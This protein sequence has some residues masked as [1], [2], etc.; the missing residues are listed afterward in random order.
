MVRLAALGDSITLGMG[1]P[2]P[3]GGWRG[4]AALLADSAGSTTFRNFASSGALSGDVAG[5]Q[6]TQALRWQPDLATVLVGMNDCL[7]GTFHINAIGSRLHQVVDTLCG[8]RTR[9]VLSCL[10]EPGRMLGLPA[11]LARPL[12]RRVQAINE[13][14]HA[15]AARYPVTHLHLADD[16]ANVADR[17]MWSIDRLH[18]SERGHRRLAG[19]AYDALMNDGWQLGERPGQ[20]PLNKPPTRRA[21]AWWMATKGTRW[22]YARSTDLVPQ[23]MSLAAH[24]WRLMRRGLTAQLD[25]QMADEVSAVLQALMPHGHD[26]P[27][28]FTT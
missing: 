26:I 8:C 24:E 17:R 18:P 5:E 6:L 25:V 4:W 2:L 15:L 10:P 22:I 14:V 21:Q 13:I 16:D 7:R 27:P 11:A 3:A 1:D 12:A 28:L 23:L 20:E 19:L 9:V